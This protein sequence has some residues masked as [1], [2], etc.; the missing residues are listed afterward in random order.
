MDNGTLFGVLSLALLL[1]FVGG[2]IWIFR[3]SH[4]AIFEA[5]SRLPLEESTER[6]E[7]TPQ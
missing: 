7:E 6:S 2:W 3:P 1:L 5:A 4:R